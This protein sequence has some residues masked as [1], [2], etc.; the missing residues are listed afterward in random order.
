MNLDSLSDSSVFKD[1]SSIPQIAFSLDMHIN[2]IKQR[3][4]VYFVMLRYFNWIIGLMNKI[5]AF[6]SP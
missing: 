3:L 1:N 2:D 5:R 6:S 4:Y